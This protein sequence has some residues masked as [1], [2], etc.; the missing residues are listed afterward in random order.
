MKK[1]I[2]ILAGLLFS[3]VLLQAQSTE[4]YIMKSGNIIGYYDIADVDSI[5]F[6]EPVFVAGQPFTDLRDFNVYQTME[7]FGQVWM[8]ENLKYLPSVVGSATGSDTDPYYYVYDYQGTNVT[9]AKA[10]ANYNIYGVLYN[11]TAA[12][13]G[14]SSSSTS[15]SG[16]QGVCPAGWHLPS[17]A[18]WVELQNYAAGTSHLMEAGDI[19]ELEFG[20]N[21]T[22][23][24]A[25]PGGMRNQSNGSFSN[26][27]T[28]GYWWTTSSAPAGEG[29]M[30][31]IQHQ[32]NMYVGSYS[33]K[34]YGYS[35]RC[36]KN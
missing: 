6:Y 22:G 29:S 23:F 16:V 4:M 18:E 36:V 7:I 31:N 30:V 1:L 8:A 35:V 20:D 5:I 13:N 21:Y 25:R 27:N 19:W 17:T 24:T 32:D 28:N 9:E 12:M 15:P 34:E 11:W 10:T 2:V 33:E 26:K 3:V 14:A